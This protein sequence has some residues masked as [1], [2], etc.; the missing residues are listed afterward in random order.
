MILETRFE[1]REGTVTLVDVMPMGGGAQ[2]NI[3]LFGW[4][5]ETAAGSPCIRSSFCAFGYGAIVP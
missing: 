3:T 4:C 5:S 1:C 2:S